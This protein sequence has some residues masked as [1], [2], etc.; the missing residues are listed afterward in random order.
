MPNLE[1]AS[2]P[3]A[4]QLPDD[5]HH[6]PFHTCI[7]LE[8]SNQARTSSID[9]EWER[10]FVVP[11][12]RNALPTVSARPRMETL[13]GLGTVDQPAP[14]LVPK[15]RRSAGSRL[16]VSMVAATLASAVAFVGIRAWENRQPSS[17]A[18]ALAS[19]APAALPRSAETPSWSSPAP[20]ALA[21][22][23]PALAS[24]IELAPA[25]PA[26]LGT[27]E[28]RPISNATHPSAAAPAHRP[29]TSNSF[30]ARK[31]VLVA[32]DNPY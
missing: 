16:F 31:V 24:N 3:R 14:T 6:I 8:D 13:P 28:P 29:L 22:R 23:A 2:S 1:V 12:E 18:I 20:V 11:T 26:P 17:I 5:P 7:R 4:P 21:A 9:A 25:K 32:T 10:L 27:P 30:R 19:V 15:P